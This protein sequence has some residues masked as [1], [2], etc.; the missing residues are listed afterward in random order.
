MAECLFTHDCSLT[1][2]LPPELLTEVLASLPEVSS[3]VSAALTCRT[4]YQL[5]T[6]EHLNIPRRVISNEI[7]PLVILEAF[8]AVD[9]RH[10]DG[11]LLSWLPHKRP[12]TC[13]DLLQGTASF[14]Q[15]WSLTTC[16][17]MSRLHSKIQDLSNQ[18]AQSALDGL[19][20]APKGITNGPL[21]N[22]ERCRI[23]TAF[24]RV[25]TYSALYEIQPVHYHWQRNLTSNYFRRYATWE[26]EQFACIWNWLK[27]EAWEGIPE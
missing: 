20:G 11:W 3:L 23:E 9:A 7:A 16:V 1:Q 19:R 10:R 26:N 5:A 27:D 4:L 2:A 17:H 15:Y 24:Y 13:E 8:T 25:E 12:V 18:F 6:D 21:S 14:P 22:L